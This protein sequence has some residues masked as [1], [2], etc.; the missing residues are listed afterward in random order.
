MLPLWYPV[1]AQVYAVKLTGHLCVYSS[2]EMSLVRDLLRIRVRGGGGNSL[3]FLFFVDHC[4]FTHQ[5]A[6]TTWRKT[7]SFLRRICAFSH[8]LVFANVNQV[9]LVENAN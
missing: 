5:G 3:L 2:P 4:A 6:H 1:T 7:N 8:G 9:P